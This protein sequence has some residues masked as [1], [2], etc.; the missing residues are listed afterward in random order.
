MGLAAV[1]YSYLRQPPA[2]DPWTYA[3]LP[4]RTP[5]AALND[6]AAVLGGSRG[7]YLKT[8]PPETRTDSHQLHFEWRG[9][10]LQARVVPDGVDTFNGRLVWDTPGG[11]RTMCRGVRPGGFQVMDLSDAWVLKLLVVRM[12]SE[13]KPTDVVATKQVKKKR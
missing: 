11:Y 7:R 13:G 12:D 2:D 10:P 3:D 1:A 9:K 6:I 5:D 8:V 4:D